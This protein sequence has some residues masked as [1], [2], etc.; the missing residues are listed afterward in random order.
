VAALTVE[1]LNKSAIARAMRLAWNTVHGW[2]ERA[3]AWCRR[4]NH[5]EV[6]QLS[7]VELQADEIQTIVG[8]KEQPIWIFVVLD[9]WSRLWPATV[10]GKRSYR[11]TLDLFRNLSQRMNPEVIPLITTDGF[12]FYKKVIGRVFGPACV[13]GQVIKTRR[14]DRVVRVERKV[15]IGSGTVETSSTG[16]GGFRNPEHLVC[17]TA[18]SDD[19]PGFSVSGPPNDMSGPV[20][21]ASRRSPGVTSL[22]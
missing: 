15:M 14:N 17:R 19:P 11:S 1:G 4:F 3:A 7:I 20:E 12:Q 6:R 2:L 9:V 8:G 18:E 22:L 16:L 13:Y 5:R 21:A 10:I